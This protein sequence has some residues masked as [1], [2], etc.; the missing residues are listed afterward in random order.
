MVD[1]L[2]PGQRKILFCCFKR[3][4]KKDIKVGVLGS[5][6][7]QAAAAY[8]PGTRLA[9]MQVHLKGIGRGLQSRPEDLLGCLQTTH[10]ERDN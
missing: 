3:N 5:N 6:T 10:P 2:K 8:L 1:G 9:S 7:T 4:L